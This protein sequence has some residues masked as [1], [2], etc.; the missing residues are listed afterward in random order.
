MPLRVGKPLIYRL[1]T[2][3][4]LFFSSGG[5]GRCLR[6]AKMLNAE[7]VA[8]Y[9]ARKLLCSE[10]YKYAAPTA[11]GIWRKANR[12]PDKRLKPLAD[13]AGVLHTAEAVF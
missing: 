13:D 11:L 3:Y 2:A 8:R 7:Y 1:F 6:T 10:F 12:V 9:G 4:E 5:H